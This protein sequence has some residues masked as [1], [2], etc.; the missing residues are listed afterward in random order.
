MKETNQ[1]AWGTPH[2]LGNLHMKIILHHSRLAQPDPVQLLMGHVGHLGTLP[3]IEVM[4][5]ESSGNLRFK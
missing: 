3:R 4:I 1:Q 2:D 5:V